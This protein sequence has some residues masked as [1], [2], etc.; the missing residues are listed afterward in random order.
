MFY[1]AIAMPRRRVLAVHDENASMFMIRRFIQGR[2]CTIVSSTEKIPNAPL[3]Q[4]A[5]GQFAATQDV[6][7]ISH[8]NKRAFKQMG[9]AAGC[10]EISN[11]CSGALQRLLVA[12]R[13]CAAA[14]LLTSG[15]FTT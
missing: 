5:T 13:L 2:A 11:S 8:S 1:K 4:S 7:R 12:Y 14:T 3:M 10:E 15:T 6:P 9:A